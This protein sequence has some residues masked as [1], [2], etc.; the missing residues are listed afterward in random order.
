[1]AETNKNPDQKTGQAEVPHS[2]SIFDVV[3]HLNREAGMSAIEWPEDVLPC[4]G[5]KFSITGHLLNQDEKSIGGGIIASSDDRITAVETVRLLNLAYPQIK[6]EVETE[7]QVHNPG[8]KIY[9]REEIDM[10][11]ARKNISDIDAR[12]E[13]G[14]AATM[15]ELYTAVAKLDTVSGTHRDYKANEIVDIMKGI[16]KIVKPTTKDLQTIPRAYGMRKK[17][18]ELNK[19]EPEKD[20]RK[21]QF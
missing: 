15:E 2:D 1:M 12:V 17:F 21:L 9:R 10:D 18:I 4:Y 14:E 20:W 8:Y 7:E 16:A 19:P 6:A 11:Y 3:D 13:L 5:G